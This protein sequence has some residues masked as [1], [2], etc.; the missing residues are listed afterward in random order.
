VFRAQVVTCVRG[1]A[2]DL[3][4]ACVALP[5]LLCAFCVISNCK[6]ER[7][8]IVEISRK[9]EKYSKGKDSGIQVDHWIA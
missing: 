1:C 6:G 4:L 5:T 9:Q 7:L 3:S 2:E 8:Q